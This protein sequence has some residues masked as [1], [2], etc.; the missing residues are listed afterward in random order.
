MLP[1]YERLMAIASLLEKKRRDK[2]NYL[3]LIINVCSLETFNLM[4]GGGGK[5]EQN[6]YIRFKIYNL[7]VYSK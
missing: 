3:I 4:S 2:I 6:G 7:P 5:G 1:R